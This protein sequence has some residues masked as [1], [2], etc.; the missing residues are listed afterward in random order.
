MDCAGAAL[1]ILTSS[2]LLPPEILNPD[3]SKRVKKYPR[4]E[5]THKD[6]VQL[7]TLPRT[8]QESHSLSESIVQ[9]FSEL[10]Q[11][12]GG[13]IIPWGAVPVPNNPLGE[14]CF[15]NIQ[16]IGTA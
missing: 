11:P 16:I 12:W 7:L 1:Q 10:W 9:T 5:G 15:P 8:P 4:L 13:V 14:E 2:P 3:A 6:Q